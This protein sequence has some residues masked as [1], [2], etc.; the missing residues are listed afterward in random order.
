MLI[1]MDQFIVLCVLAKKMHRSAFWE[2][3]SL[4]ALTQFDAS[5]NDTRRDAFTE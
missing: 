2:H 1:K 3:T 5:K 4:G